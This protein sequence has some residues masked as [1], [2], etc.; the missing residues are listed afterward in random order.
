ML[1]KIFEWPVKSLDDCLNTDLPDPSCFVRVGG[2]GTRDKESIGKRDQ[3]QEIELEQDNMYKQ[4][5]LEV[6]II[7]IATLKHIEK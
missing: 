2:T 3:R 7:S 4:Y 6:G 5:H 1:S